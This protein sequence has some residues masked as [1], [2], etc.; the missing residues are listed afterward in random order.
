MIFFTNRLYET[1]AVASPDTH[2]GLVLLDDELN[3]TIKTG[4]AIYTAKIAKNNISVEK[5][6]AGSFVFVPNFNNKIIPLEVMEVEESRSYKKIIAEDAGLELL[7]SDVGDHK[8]KGTLREHIMATIGNDSDWVIGIDE[9]GDSR[10]LTLEYTGVSNQTKRIVQ[11]A[12]RFGAEISYDF[13]F[14][15]NEIKEKR[16]NFVKE[17][18]KDTARRLEIGKELKDVKRNVSIAN[19]RTAVL[20]IGK[21][22]KENIKTKK[23]VKKTVKVND[24][25]STIKQTNGKLDAF[26]GWF[27]AR[28]GKVSYS[29]YS[30]MGPNSYDCSS[31]VHFAAKHAG[32]LPSNHYIGSTET[33][34][35]MKG[36]YLDEI[37]RSEI[38]YGDIFVA[39]RQGASG[40]AAG[41]TGAVLD[42]NRIIHCT[43]SKN[44]IAIT[45]INGYT[46]GPP[47]RFFRWR[48]SGAGTVSV[49]NAKYWTNN[50]IAYHD[51]GW[52]LNGLNAGQLNNWIRA[53][54]PS[55]PFNGQ[56]NVFMEAQ[57]QS[58]L[59]ARY[60]LA[61]A[62]L[63]SGWGRSNIA[64]RYNNYFGIGA[65]DN[66]PNNAKNFSNSGL[67]SGIINGAKWIAKNYYNSSYKQTTL[68]KMRNN[69]GVHQYATDPN[70]HNKIANIMKGSERYTRPA[71]PSEN[72]TKEVLE[73]VTE[74][75]E[76]E[77]ETNLKGYKYDD[78]RYFVD[79][80]GRVCD[81]EANAIWSKPNTKGRY[82]SRVYESEATSQKTLF[83]ECLNQLKKNNQPE[84]S[85]DV[86]PDKIPKDIDI[87]DRVRIIDHDYSPA[88][89][90]E[91]RLVD[92][93]TS[94]TNDYID[95][96]VFA[97][98]VPKTSGIAERLLNLQ[99]N[100]QDFKYSFENQ[101]YVMSLESSSG[102]VFKD[103]IVDTNLIAKLTKA[104][105]DQSA[106]VDGYIW[107]RISKYPD[108]L[109]VKDEEWNENHKDLNE[110]FIELSR[111]DIELEATFVCSAML[112]NLAVATA[113]YTIKNLSIG[114][115][116]QKEEPDRK[117]LMWGDIWQ[118]EE[119]ETKFKRIWKGDR[120]EDTVTKRDLELL[121]LTP[122]PPGQD[123]KDGM[124]G[125]PGADGKTSYMHF[126]YAD[127][128]DGVV[129]FTLTATSGKKYIGFYTDFVK[130]D[131]KDPTKYEWSKYV[132]DDG[133]PGK[134]GV[135]GI[136]GKAGADGKT[137]Y[138]HTA[139]ANSADGSKDFSTSQ[140]GEKMY[141][142]TYTDYTKEDSTDP[143]KYTWQL[144]K[145]NK[146][147]KGI[148]GKDG[149]VLTV[150]AWLEGE[151][152]NYKT[153]DVK[154]IIQAKYDGEDIKVD[155]SN[156]EVYNCY[157]N[158]EWTRA[159]LSDYWAN[160]DRQYEYIANKVVVSYK[161]L[162][163][164]AY[165]RLDNI[166]D[167]AN[168][169]PGKDGKDGM[170]GK[171]G[172]D[173]KTSYMH[174]AYADS[175]D[176]VVGFTLTA[177]PGRKYI[178]FYTDFVKEDS[179]DPTKYEWSKYVGDD[180]KPGKDGQNGI[181]GK[182]GADGKTPYFHTAWANSNDGSKDFS[183]S[184]AGEKL[185][186]GTYTDYTK[187]DSRDPKKYTWQLVKGNTGP[188]G[189]KGDRGPIGPKGSDGKDGVDGKTGKIGQ[190]LLRNSNVPVSNKDYNTKI[191]TLCETPTTGET[192]T[193]T[194]KIKMEKDDSIGLYNSGGSIDFYGFAQIKKTDDYQ[195]WSKSFKW[196][197]KSAS[198]YKQKNPPSLYLYIYSNGN[199]NNKNNNTV[200]I[201]WA[202]LT[203]GDIPAI[204]WSPCYADVDD[205]ISEKASEESLQDLQVHFAM[206]PTAEELNQ[207]KIDLMKQQAYLDQLKTAID[208]NALSL[209]DRLSIIEAN[210]GAGKLSLEAINTYLHFGEE[211]VL[212][213]KE[214]EQ[215]RLRLINNALEITDGSKVVA[216]FANN[217]T[218]TPN[219]KVSGAF[220]FGYHVAN[221]VDL[222]GN[223]YTVISANV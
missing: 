91:A 207:N 195:I 177:T 122:G 48:N 163:A 71:A 36:K 51:L 201:E 124:P 215:V 4:T 222:G 193:F 16:I 7:N 102:N 142:G 194:A 204:E 171:P 175:A 174:F 218:E 178:G 29:M 196:V 79:K 183:T 26:I 197:D 213:G 203:R 90:L 55:S 81:R 116:K 21:P 221:K 96:A 138:F 84:V 133:K 205:A 131:S 199:G 62:A 179:K 67:A 212:I 114:I 1:L 160:W 97:N 132:G 220:E 94:S 209:E 60:I 49:S 188:K 156:T 105:I 30:R 9:I 150:E 126:A 18:G 168:G 119:G 151:F 107:E 154:R 83:D 106:N 44:G 50:N 3:Q 8:M 145:G 38:K 191:W 137:P 27:Q 28:K 68:Y 180:G 85:Y 5:I 158:G 170:P 208:S 100:V 152:R 173:G 112:D 189:D 25:S 101:P 98:F 6:E 63:E 192:M 53:T 82:L 65:F 206:Y 19:L 75:K 113:S 129:G 89:Y 223:K 172:A 61:H 103:D 144:V 40:G 93:T 32:L 216:R 128:Q 41:H 157:G 165:A 35:A 78:G 200:S 12:G 70:W 13:K 159:P 104:G 77:K 17:R 185:Y 130:E 111:S 108:K 54:S 217:Q 110:H 134:D 187:E 59:D 161:G 24:S 87:G 115:Y 88:L 166:K 56:G 153:K 143:K 125:K 147:E 164:E 181:P 155:D 20:G 52:T 45:S 219:L 109:V 176:G 167:G 99:A 169:V 64:K 184:Q 22:C 11:I 33:L 190:N 74:N 15:G 95:R 80:D 92:V 76:V 66:D 31:A 69:N 118:W 10:N 86:N 135:N 42:K 198:G 210:V 34:F 37:S 211:G 123:G 47:V 182:A 73:T 117:L 186:I 72:K 43:Y 146:G 148:D 14:D 58:G 140:A 57:K 136:P 141:I 162:K 23:T 46:G 202:T 120:W 127:S 39:G 139:W 149:H 121:E 2:K 214:G